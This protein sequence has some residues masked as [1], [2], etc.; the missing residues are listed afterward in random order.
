VELK[1]KVPM[2]PSWYRAKLLKSLCCIPHEGGRAEFLKRKPALGFTLE[3]LD[4]LRAHVVLLLPVQRRL[5][6]MMLQNNLANKLDLLQRGKV[7]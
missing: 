1:A 7:D 3:Q 5:L 2:V 6:F 4:L